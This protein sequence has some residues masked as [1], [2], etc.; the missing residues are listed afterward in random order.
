LARRVG[1]RYRLQA[2]QQR[3]D[4]STLNDTVNKYQRGGFCTA[5]KVDTSSRR[6]TVTERE[7]GG[8]RIAKVIHHSTSERLILA[9]SFSTPGKPG[10]NDGN[11]ILFLRPAYKSRDLAHP[12]REPVR[13]FAALRAGPWQAR[14]DACSLARIVATA[15][16]PSTDQ[17]LPT[18]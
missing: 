9:I 3:G 8:I 18:C 15:V 2:W 7:S 4:A 16:G 10:A 14:N 11:Q 5:K 12:K 1:L 17:S 13:T 6:C